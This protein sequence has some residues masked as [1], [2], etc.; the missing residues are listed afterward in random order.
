MSDR[1][2][3]S[4]D[5]S[6]YDYRYRAMWGDTDLSTGFRMT[7]N[8]VPVVYVPKEWAEK[9]SFTNN[10]QYYS[11]SY[12][13]KDVWQYMKPAQ[14]E[15]G[16]W[17]KTLASRLQ[18]W[19]SDPNTGY[20]IDESKFKELK[21]NALPVAQPRWTSQGK[22]NPPIAGIGENN[23]QLVY[24]G[25]SGDDLNGEL[26]IFDSSGKGNLH[27]VTSSSSA[28]AK[29]GR[30]IGKLG[31]ATLLLNAVVPGLG[32]AIYVGTN[33]GNAVATGNWGRAALNIALASV[34]GADGASAAQGTMFEIPAIANSVGTVA[35]T[36]GVSAATAGLIV[37]GTMNLIANGG[38]LKEA[39]RTTLAQEL[40]S[41]AAGYASQLAGLQGMKGLDTIL[42]SVTKESTTALLLN[43]DVESAAKGAFVGSAIPFALQSTP[44]WESLSKTQQ[45]ALTSAAISAASGGKMDVGAAIKNYTSQVF[46]DAA[47]EKVG[48]T[49]T[50]SQKQLA[51]QAITA[52]IQGKPLDAA[53]QNFAISEART[54]IKNQVA[55]AEGW[56]DDAQKQ[57]AI[58]AYGSKVNPNDYSAK[59]Q[60]WED[61]AEKQAALKSYGEKVTPLGF[62]EREQ[63]KSIDPG[64]NAEAYAKLNDV[65]GDPFQHFLEQG[66]KTNLPTNYESGAEAA[67]KSI[68]YKAN[69]DEVK[70]VADLFKSSA[71]PDVALGKYYNERWVSP[72]EAAATAKAA[73]FELTPE[74]LAKFTGQARNGQSS[75]FEDIEFAAKIGKEAQQQRE[76]FVNNYLA[77]ITKAYEDQGYTKAQIAA[78]MPD[79]RSGLGAT[80]DAYVNQ[81]KSYS[82]QV[83]GLYGPQ[84]QEFA[85]AQRRLLDAQAQMGGYGLVKESSGYK[86]ATG[87]FIPLQTPQQ[88]TVWIQDK[89]KAP[90]APVEAG[91]RLMIS[92]GAGTPSA[93]SET[94]RKEFAAIGIPGAAAP[95][96]SSEG[97]QKSALAGEIPSGKGDGKV[98][99]LFGIPLSASFAD[100][101]SDSWVRVDQDKWVTPDNKYT[102]LSL[103]GGGEV[104]DVQTQNIVAKLTPQETTQITPVKP[105]APV[106]PQEQVSKTVQDIIKAADEK[107]ISP[108][109]AQ[110]ALE[111]AMTGAGYK[112]TPEEI[113]TQVAALQGEKTPAQLQKDITG[114]L[115]P[116][117]VTEAE[118]R[119]AYQEAGLQAPTQADI[120]RF[121]GQREQALLTPDIQKY[122]PTASANVIT[123]QGSALK[124]AQDAAAAKAAAD[125]AAAAKQASDITAKITA[126]DKKLADFAVQTGQGF[127]DVKAGFDAAFKDAQAK[128]ASADQALQ[129]A[130][131]KVSADA[132]AGQKATG[133]QIGKLGADVGAVQSA[134]S[135]LGTATQTQFGDV[136]T[137]ITQLQQQGMS[138]AEATSQALRELSSGQTQLGQQISQQQQQTQTKFGEIDARVA[139][140]QQQ[141]LSQADATN[142][143]LQELAGQQS[144][145]GQQIGTV[146]TGLGQQIGSIGQQVGGL[147]QQV[148]GLGQ[149]LTGLIG[150]FGTTTQG[151]QQQIQQAQQ[152]AQMGNLL[153]ILGLAQRE[154]K[155][156]PPLALVGEIK[157]YDFSSDLLAGVYK[158]NTM[159]QHSA[160]NQL[161][162]LTRG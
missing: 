43:K 1:L 84:S 99:T 105:P 128:G 55:Q 132:A 13:N 125:Q 29:L 40:G 49:M 51:R 134:V 11:P 135:Q 143:A 26:A 22:P 27:T 85:D 97:T 122:L 44:G 18:G 151:M 102:F 28:L 33:V 70:Q 14:L 45:S 57:Q 81:L 157:P 5:N 46:A 93:A 152:Q 118:V 96:L 67:L 149:A 119:R 38:D 75:V 107:R 116:R 74:Q 36:L 161:L 6:K 17:N 53:L 124:A 104:R 58:S 131:N 15:S 146:Q 50:D 138:Q 60:G 41:A 25:K 86:S 30:T 94:I 82:E 47:L 115:D 100:I 121:I 139:Q 87:E 137:R 90:V 155:P 39:L 80:A 8:G 117:M 63:V 56:K 3:L 34:P 78:A 130:I 52:S 59:Q 79:I 23:G 48:G 10:T 20:I 76:T 148:G 21:L 162:K 140:L 2:I 103:P 19:V 65:A 127:A 141:G 145:L 16:D 133:E 69:P 37:N 72:E 129:T 110:K 9:G 153:T 136:N 64:F 147:G 35:S 4:G 111:A 160:N 68:G 98:P 101:G 24:V 142:K 42:K 77:D 150:Q 32:T 114:Y 54:A 120:N 91:D 159:N 123:E 89:T 88:P 126:T 62:K 31:P 112:A 144:Q 113:Q 156:Q 61:Y 108:Q 154:S 95:V 73:G 109:E 106:V 7:Y 83:K 158:P 71:D 92:G 12:L 66:Q